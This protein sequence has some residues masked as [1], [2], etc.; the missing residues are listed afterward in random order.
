M[1][2]TVWWVIFIISWLTWQS[3]NFHSWSLMPTVVSYMREVDRW[4]AWPKTLWQH[5][6]LF[7]VLA[8]NS[9]HYHPVD[10]I[11]N[12]NILLSRALCPSL[13]R[14][15]STMRKI[16]SK[17]K[18]MYRLYHHLCSAM[19]LDWVEI[20]NHKNNS[21]GLLWLSTKISTRHTVSYI[22]VH[23]TCPPAA[24]NLAFMITLTRLCKGWSWKLGMGRSCSETFA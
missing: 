15:G 4:W 1:P 23:F 18:C 14:C 13:C 10:G 9:S 2:Y 7:T 21:E 24:T 8:S 16:T 3:R 22:H 5:G 11:L 12:T 17:I 6:Q 19:P 20:K